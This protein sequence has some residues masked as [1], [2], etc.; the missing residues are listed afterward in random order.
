M[1]CEQYQSLPL[2][3]RSPEDRLAIE[4]AKVLYLYVLWRDG[5]EPGYSSLNIGAGAPG[6]TQLSSEPMGAII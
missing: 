3:E 2:D 5:A 1:T 4:L 6:A